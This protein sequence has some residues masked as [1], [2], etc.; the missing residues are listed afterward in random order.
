MM[1]KIYFGKCMRSG[2]CVFQ[3]LL[4]TELVISFHYSIFKSI[5]LIQN[6]SKPFSNADE[7]SLLK[8][9]F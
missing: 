7:T 5:I 1:I 9:Y 2:Y 8:K 4:Y 3:H 6:H